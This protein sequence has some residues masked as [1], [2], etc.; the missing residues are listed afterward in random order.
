L[1]V[2]YFETRPTGQTV[3]R[4]RE[5]ETIRAFLTGQGL[6]SALDLF[7]TFVFIAVL[8]AY[9]WKLTLIVLATIPLYLII[10]A[11]TRPL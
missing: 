5:L 10:A 1:P 9:S 6:F 4:V 11:L 7:F 2:S 3:A 8:F